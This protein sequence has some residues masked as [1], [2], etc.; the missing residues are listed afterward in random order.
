MGNKQ[1]ISDQN[2]QRLSNQ[3]E[4]IQ[5]IQGQESKMNFNQLK[6]QL[7][8]EQKTFSMLGVS[9]VIARN[10]QGKFLAVK[11]NYN[12]GWWI[13]GGLVDP[14]EDFVTAA[15]R[16]TQEEAGIDIEIK[17][18][19]RIEHNFKKSARYKVV[20]YGEPK[21][22]NQI[23]KQIPDSETQ[24][25][26]WVT[27]KELEELGKQP[28]YLR[29]KE[30]LYFGSYIENGGPIYPLSIIETTLV[31]T[32]NFKNQATANNKNTSDKMEI[33]YQL[34]QQNNQVQKQN[35]NDKNIVPLNV[36]LQN[37]PSNQMIGLSLIVIRNQEGKFLAVKET[38][39]RGWWLP[40]GKVDPPEDFISAAIRESK[41][42]AG[43]DI[44][45]KG[46]LRIEQDYRKGFLR[47]KVVFYAEPIDQKQKP[48]D[49][50]D[51]ESEEAAWVTLKELKVLGNSPPYLRGT[52]L[53]E[54]GQYLE[55]GGPYYPLDIIKQLK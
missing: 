6:Q 3:K 30:L 52:E 34:N 12:Q 35:Q 17:G 38:K 45:V 28:P 15:I 48:K 16:E 21:D 5:Q 7:I 9:L 22:Q 47:Y 41:E 42:E 33:E 37:A 19:L 20:F 11:E 23:P 29:G 31:N 27:L 32:F 43:I 50:A 25:A 24:E 46:V 40:G 51:N 55:K 39:N 26:R 13:P 49:F 14:P 18:I 36:K 54:F 53:L 1:Q 44:N 2:T 4:N 10:N 8:K